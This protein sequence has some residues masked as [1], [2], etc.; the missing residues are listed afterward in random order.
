MA[1]REFWYG[2]GCGGSGWLL[3]PLIIIQS[4]PAYPHVSVLPW[5][6][7][8]FASAGPTTAVTADLA[9][10]NLLVLANTTVPL[11]SVTYL[12][13]T[14]PRLLPFEHAVN[15]TYGLCMSV[16]LK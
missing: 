12:N 2:A 11:L 8:T 4:G 7:S 14:G 9:S 6:N 16:Q 3:I 15:V 13:Q 10:A 5:A 1:A